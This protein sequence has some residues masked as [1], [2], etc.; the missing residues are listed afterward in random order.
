MENP[1]NEKKKTTVFAVYLDFAV[2]VSQKKYSMCV[3][4]FIIVQKDT[5]CVLCYE[6]YKPMMQ[7][8]REEPAQ[9]AI[10]N[11]RISWMTNHQKTFIFFLKQYL[12]CIRPKTIPIEIKYCNTGQQSGGPLWCLS[13]Y[14]IK[15][16]EKLK[17]IIVEE[18][19]AC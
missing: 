14:C 18:Y 6:L 4:I 1:R 16:A 9:P 2:G 3:L 15:T 7:F 17:Y 11:W 13:F 5:L 12:F 10:S 8:A 19:S